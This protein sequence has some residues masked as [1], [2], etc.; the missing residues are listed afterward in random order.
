M[1]Y[2]IMIAASHVIV[3]INAVHKQNKR[4]AQNTA[5]TSHLRYLRLAG[6]AHVINGMDGKNIR[7]TKNM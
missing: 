4:V 1:L 7:R 3:Q 6:N 2:I 5:V